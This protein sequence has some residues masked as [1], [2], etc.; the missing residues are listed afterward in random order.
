MGNDPLLQQALRHYEST[1]P[2]DVDP[3][4]VECARAAR[5]AMSGNVSTGSRL[6]STNAAEIGRLDG[7]L[8][9][10]RRDLDVART[11]AMIWKGVAIVGWL[12]VAAAGIGATFRQ[13]RAEA[14]AGPEVVLTI[15]AGIADGRPAQTLER[16]WPI[17]EFTV[18]S[19]ARICERV[20]AGAAALVEP[21]RARNPGIEVV[22]RCTI[23]VTP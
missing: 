14:P 7:E 16:R 22:Y 20:K 4:L 9:R 21:I 13:A 10:A 15:V 3:R 17:P 1:D 23:E 19:D 6:A 2:G 18:I 12:I 8:R 5:P 11:R